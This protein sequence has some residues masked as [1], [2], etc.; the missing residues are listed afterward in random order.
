MMSDLVL[1]FLCAHYSEGVLSHSPGLR[2]KRAT[3]GQ[4]GQTVPYPNGVPPNGCGRNP[5]GVETTQR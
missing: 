4:I 5:V 1:I 2:A 3:L